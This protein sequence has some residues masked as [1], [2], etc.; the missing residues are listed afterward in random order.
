MLFALKRSQQ[1]RRV[2]LLSLTTPP[3]AAWWLLSSLRAPAPRRPW[4]PA[5]EEDLSG[6]PTSPQQ[7]LLTALAVQST[8]A[9]Q[10]HSA[11]GPRPQPSPQPP[12][13]MRKQAQRW[14]QRTQAIFDPRSVSPHR[15]SW[16]L[17]QDQ[18][19][20]VGSWKQLMFTSISMCFSELYC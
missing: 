8:C 11:R 19:L 9:G 3:E 15:R 1:N 6:L 13:H 4:R 17:F 18:Y 2:R 14:Y 5:G 10:A 7:G 16:G 12:C 20:R